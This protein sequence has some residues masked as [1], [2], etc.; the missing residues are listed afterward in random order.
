MSAVWTLV[1]VKRTLSSRTHQARRKEY[2]ALAWV[3]TDKTQVRADSDQKAPRQ[4][5]LEL[6]PG[7]D[8]ACGGLTTSST[9]DR[10]P[11]RALIGAAR[12]FQRTNRRGFADCVS[13]ARFIDLGMAAS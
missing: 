9:P 10:Y 3:M 5:M 13:P 4:G 6:L 11:G 2:T 8:Q 12:S 1:G 7:R